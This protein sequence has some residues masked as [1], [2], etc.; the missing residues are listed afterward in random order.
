[1]NCN[2]CSPYSSAVPELITTSFG[3]EVS[4]NSS[5]PSA[6]LRI[7]NNCNTYFSGTD[8]TLPTVSKASESLS[9]SLLAQARRTTSLY[10]KKTKPVLHIISQ[11]T[12]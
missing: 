4:A 3:I 8:M 6:V 1:M 5:N 7:T 10:Y 2:T 11:G 9:Y 12:V